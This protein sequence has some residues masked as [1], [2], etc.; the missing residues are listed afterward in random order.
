MRWRLFDE[1][2]VPDF[3]TA[4]FFARHPWVPPHGQVGHTQR[5]SM[6]AGVV[7]RHAES[8]QSLTDLGCGDGSL[9]AVLR[10]RVPRLRAWGYDA[11]VENVAVAQANGLDARGGDFLVHPVELGDVVAMSEVLEHMLDPDAFLAT[12]SAKLLVASSPSSETGDWHYHHHAWAFDMDG[13][14]ELVEGAGWRVLEH[15]QCYG[16]TNVHNGRSGR[17]YFQALAATR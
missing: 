12:L 15:T 13:F 9:L 2:T 4:E 8:Y 14:R 10:E 1:G 17:Q 6:V 5:I 16:G 11:G 3:T 7:E